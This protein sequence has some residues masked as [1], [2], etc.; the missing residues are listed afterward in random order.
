[1]SLLL[2]TPQIVYSSVGVITLL[3]TEVVGKLVS[4]SLS[5][6]SNIYSYM[7]SSSENVIINKYKNELEIMDIELKLKLV[8]QWLEKINLDEIKSNSS[9]ELIYS[10]ISESCHKISDCIEK[11]NDQIKYHQ[12]RW[13]HTWRTLYLDTELEL[14][15]RSTLIL[16][17]RLR[18][19]Q[20]VK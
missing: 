20:L 16:N 13:F 5:G 14:L 10:G 19:I 2:A 7:G 4:V 11:M 1:M 9:L 17:E 8:G 12:S 6:L 3:S 15:K 18:L